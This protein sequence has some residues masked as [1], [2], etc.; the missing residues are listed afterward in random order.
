MCHKVAGALPLIRHLNQC[1]LRG[2][3]PLTAG[4]LSTFERHRLD[5]AKDSATSR[6]SFIVVVHLRRC[7]SEAV[8]DF[9][10]GSL[11]CEEIAERN[12]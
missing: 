4:P 7:S 12:I 8:A 10:M 1:L 9:P 3:A 2:L 6:I 5:R 11:E